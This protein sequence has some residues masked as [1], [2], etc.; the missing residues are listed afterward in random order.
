MNKKRIV[1]CIILVILILC[2]IF[3]I[4]MGVFYKPKDYST[5]MISDKRLRELY[6]NSYKYYLL[7]EG[8]ISRISSDDGIR[9]DDKT[10]TGIVGI[11]NSGDIDKL[12]DNTFVSIYRDKYYNS[13][14]NGREFFEVGGKF[15]Y[16]NSDIVFCD[17]LIT[18]FD[19][20]RVT[21][22]NSDRVSIHIGN[23]VVSA[24]LEDNDWYLSEP[25]FKCDPDIGEE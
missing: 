17:T 25:L 12:I 20:I 18:R 14:I 21:S 9:V 1:L 23:R 6:D 2:S 11:N 7:Y 19:D 24:Y 13:L 8:D 10:Y 22:T 5:D 15:Y 16:N 4:Y 3:V